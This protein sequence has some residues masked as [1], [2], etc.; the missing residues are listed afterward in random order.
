MKKWTLDKKLSSGT[1]GSIYRAFPSGSTLSPET[2]KLESKNP[3]F[4]ILKIQD[5]EEGIPNDIF[6]EMLFHFALKQQPNI[7]ESLHSGVG[8]FKGAEQ[9]EFIFRSLKAPE[10]TTKVQAENLGS[11]LGNLG[12][13][14]RS[15]IPKTLVPWPGGQFGALV[16]REY[17]HDLLQGLQARKFSLVQKLNLW[18]DMLCGIYTMHLH[19]IIYVDMKPENIF[20]H[21]HPEK[22]FL[23]DFGLSVPEFFAGSSCWQG[24][25][26]YS[27]PEVLLSNSQPCT[28]AHDSW[29]LGMTTWALFYETLPVLWDT[30]SPL[31][32]PQIMGLLKSN[33][34]ETKGTE[35]TF[36]TDLPRLVQLLSLMC[37]FGLP[38]T[39]WVERFTDPLWT[40]NVLFLMK[41]MQTEGTFLNHWKEQRRRSIL[42]QIGKSHPLLDLI[43]WKLIVRFLL[44]FDPT[45]R[46]IN[47]NTLF[48]TFVGLM[49]VLLQDKTYNPDLLN[50]DRLIQDWK[51]RFR[52]CTNPN[53]REE[54]LAESKTDIPPLKLS[55]EWLKQAHDSLHSIYE[56]NPAASLVK[57]AQERENIVDAK[58]LS[59]RYILL[60][61]TDS[62]V[63]LKDI[64]LVALWLTMKNH[65]QT[66]QF[67]L[68]D[69]CSFA[70]CSHRNRASQLIAQRM[71]TYLLPELA[72]HFAPSQSA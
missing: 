6:Y 12:K 15:R 45:K 11:N 70:N 68:Q 47:M 34:K 23:A 16:L 36:Q 10:A 8:N 53:P 46:M 35:K 58:R 42:S 41:Q 21:T 27:P 66:Y 60:F 33:M 38:E 54:K 2:K 32:V 64:Y 44:V 50:S 59:Q 14:T 4:S 69:F 71:I 22:A 3:P 43:F 37:V 52:S 57:T 49:T 17:D 7:A 24:T 31:L 30:S 13:R 72:R 55:V 39:E 67:S 40:P 62:Q 26:A 56:T 28:F 29:T 5:L 25:L 61:P 9:K 20:V 51:E 63:E 48:A 1:S 18:V 65:L 19:H